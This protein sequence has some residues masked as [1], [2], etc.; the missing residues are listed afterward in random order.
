[1][2]GAG[3][4]PWP[5]AARRAAV[6]R[7]FDFL[8]A[9][10]ALVT[11]LPLFVLIALVVVL[12]SPGPVFYRDAR[13][14]FRGRP[15]RMLKFRKMRAG[16]TGGN[17]TLGDDARLTR[18]GAWL[19]RTKLDELPQLWHVLRGEMSL[20]G[21]RPESPSCVARHRV[22][23][24]VI[25]SVRPGITGFTQLAFAREGWILDPD[26]PERH[27]LSLLLPQKVALDRLYADRASLRTDLRI[28][29]GTILTVMFRRPL[30]VD[31]R[32]GALTFRRR[33]IPGEPMP[34]H[35]QARPRPRRTRRRRAPAIARTVGRK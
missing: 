28:L 24:E 21:P 4:S 19:A 1:V 11:L 29:G 5:L 32:T 13:A 22:D 30:A 27:Y 8:V 3:R 12:D 7:A 33:R 17:L 26:D 25:L 6:K 10:L 9:L 23:Y 15:L 2:T 20:V 16:A 34:V 18:V 35:D 31:R 14:G